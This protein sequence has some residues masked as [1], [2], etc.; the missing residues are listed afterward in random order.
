LAISS[1]VL[2]FMTKKVRLVKKPIAMAPSSALSKAG[3]RLFTA[4]H[5]KDNEAQR[6]ASRLIQSSQRRNSNGL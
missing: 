4:Q 2:L 1:T 5:A 6:L 3:A